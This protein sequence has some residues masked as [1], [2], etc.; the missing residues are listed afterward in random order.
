MEV[1]FQ[2]ICQK[3]PK[4]SPKYENCKQALKEVSK[5]CPGSAEKLYA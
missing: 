5:V 1:F 2:T 4:D 3:T